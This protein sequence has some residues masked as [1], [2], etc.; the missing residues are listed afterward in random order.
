MVFLNVSQL[1][2]EQIN[3]ATSTSPY[4]KIL[5]TT[6]VHLSNFEKTKKVFTETSSFQ[7]TESSESSAATKDSLGIKSTG[8]K[9]SGKQQFIKNNKLKSKKKNKKNDNF[10]YF[11]IFWVASNMGKYGQLSIN[12]CTSL[13]RGNTLAN[14]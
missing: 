11:L 3:Q 12:F 1:C 2:L 9:Y 7:L 4:V 14:Y 10:Y 8:T 5:S 13:Q 6:K